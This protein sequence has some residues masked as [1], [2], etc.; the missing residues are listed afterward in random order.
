MIL[1]LLQDSLATVSASPVVST[2]TGASMIDII[3]KAFIS[4]AVSGGLVMYL[5]KQISE[6]RNKTLLAKLEQAKLEQTHSN[7]LEKDIFEFDKEK[8][9]SSHQANQDFQKTIINEIFEKFVKQS[10]WITDMHDKSIER[11][12]TTLTD[13][14]RLSKD[15]YVQNDLLSNRIRNLETKNI[16]NHNEL[17]AKIDTLIKLMSNIIQLKN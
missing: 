10:Q 8:Y 9:I 11:L 6:R 17:L 12:L 15:T 7:A 13:V 1:L 2:I 5:I 4:L 3:F 16:K 14:Q